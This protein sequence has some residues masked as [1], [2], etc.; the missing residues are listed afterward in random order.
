MKRSF[1][2]LLGAI[3]D[4]E[5]D[6]NVYAN[7]HVVEDLKRLIEQYAGLM[8][9]AE[10]IYEAYVVNHDETMDVPNRPHV[11]YI[12]NAIRSVCEAMGCNDKN[13][14]GL[15]NARDCIR[16]AE[17]EENFELN[18]YKEMKKLIEKK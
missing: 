10:R 16:D 12:C 3:E 17:K 8:D 9:F 18:E 11:G 7:K 5:T 13:Q 1:E 15:I 14:Y 6:E 2:A 4:F